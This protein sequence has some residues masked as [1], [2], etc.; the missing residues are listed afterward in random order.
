MAR[1]LRILHVVDT[2]ATGGL[3]RFVTD[4]AIAQ[5]RAGH[6]VR[7]FS[8]L[9]SE[10]FRAELE[11]AGVPV[12]SGDKRPGLDLGVLRRLRAVARSVDVV[13]SHNFV[14]N[15]YAALALLGA[16]S[17]LVNTCHNMGSRLVARRLRWLYRASLARTR[18]VVAV[19]AQVRE[20][21]V[22]DGIVP[23]RLAG[24]V[25]NGVP[26][27]R[28]D[29]G[30][31][32][33]AAARARLG[34]P[35]DAL[36]VGCVGRLVALKNHALLLA[37]LPALAARLPTL[38]LVLLGDGPLRDALSSQARDLGLDARVLLA[39]ARAD[40][41][42]LLPAFDV[43]ALPSRTEGLSIA[44]IE[45]CATGLAVVASAVGGNVEI[46]DDD[47]TG[48]LVP[49]DDGPAL[50]AALARLLGDATLR[51]R[52]GAAALA[53]VA[54]NASIDAAVRGYDGVYRGALAP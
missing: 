15:Y 17:A 49:A 12:V 6:A 30:R 23:A 19:G 9:R 10:G 34:L 54:A 41:A 33:R 36:V 5:H 42:D 8:V 37:Q 29:D 18:A 20:R 1:T 35:A 2:L 25:R 40:V 47:H 31:G 27:A 21:L 4:L 48:L 16:S 53:W 14:P 13:H 24:M 28:F 26:M 50:A 7:V 43:F 38:R 3:E 32:R 46:V 51:E 44:L 45:A 22:A 11:A 52:L 39:G